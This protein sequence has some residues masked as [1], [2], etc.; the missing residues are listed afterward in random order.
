VE[1]LVV[2][3]II[4][5]LIGILMP[6]LSR[7]R[8]QAQ[9]V[10][11]MSNLR[12]CGQAALM[13]AQDNRGFI[14]TAV[15][16]STIYAFPQ[17]VAA[18]LSREL[19]GATNIFYCPSNELLPPGSQTPIETSD[20]YPPDHG[21]TWAGSPPSGRSGR[22]TYW[23]VGN[24]NGPDCKDPLTANGFPPSG[25]GYPPFH[26]LNKD[27]SIRDEYMRKVGDKGAYKIVICTDQSGQ[28]TGG[29]G[30]F[31]I[32]GSQVWIQPNDTVAAAKS[33]ARSWKNNLYGDGHADRVRPDEVEWRWGPN[34]PACW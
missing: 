20:F 17:S 33:K 25:K 27:G 3:G 11:C 14:P 6:A 16:I 12:G 7:A 30:W 22:I 5:V 2:I 29:R 23:W 9:S 21:G 10:Q 24:P 32:H 34:A 8:A 26:D 18:S 13:Y 19:K 28:L 31:F 1:L 4:A 15:T